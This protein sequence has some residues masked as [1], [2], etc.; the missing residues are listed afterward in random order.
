M[1]CLDNSEICQRIFSEIIRKTGDIHLSLSLTPNNKVRLNIGTRHHSKDFVN[2]RDALQWLIYSYNLKHLRHILGSSRSPAPDQ[3][4]VI[5]KP[6]VIT[7]SVNDI[8][9]TIGGYEYFSNELFRKIYSDFERLKDKK[10]LSKEEFDRIYFMVIEG[11][12]KMLDQTLEPRRYDVYT[13]YLD[14]FRIKGHRK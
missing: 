6:D 13:K 1:R 7:E 8:L 14:W 5:K 10:N 11:P 4:P 2:Q 12:K 9:E 3:S